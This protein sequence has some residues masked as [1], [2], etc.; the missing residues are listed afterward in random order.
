[1]Q[2]LSDVSELP[3]FAGGLPKSLAE[4][5][6]SA[7][8]EEERRVFERRGQGN[9]ATQQ[10]SLV[11]RRYASS[12]KF[13]AQSF[14]LCRNLKLEIGNLILSI[15]TLVP[16]RCQLEQAR[17]RSD[18]TFSPRRQKGT[19]AKWLP[20]DRRA[21]VDSILGTTHC[22]C[23][24]TSQSLGSIVFIPVWNSSSILQKAKRTSTSMESILC[25]R[26]PCGKTRIDSKFR[27][28]LRTNPGLCLLLCSGKNFGRP[29]LPTGAAVSG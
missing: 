12:S 22:L 24:L 17:E 21:A 15:E 16:Q 6:D 9:S 8:K 25:R 11:V 26:S 18:P 7:F 19:S 2:N 23:C 29:F 27:R 3:R 28:E 5:V 13:H 14:R 4:P 10:D 20:D 1:M